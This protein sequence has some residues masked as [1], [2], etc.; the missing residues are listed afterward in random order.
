MF[1]PRFGDLTPAGALSALGHAFFTL[2]VGMGAVMAYGAYVPDDVSIAAT[3]VAVVCMDTGIAIVTGLV[4]FPI[5][6]ANGLDP[7]EG[8]GLI[9]HTL[10]LAFGQI[11]GGTIIATIFFLLL[12]FA[13]WTSAISLLEP[14]VAWITESRG[15]SRPT[16]A[17]LIG[18]AIWALGL[19]SVLSFNVL[20]DVDFMWG[21]YFDSADFLTSNIILPLGGIAIAV[22]A[23]WAMSR[24]S[25][26]DELNLANPK[27]YRLWRFAARF[28]APTAVILV[29]LNAVG[30]LP[31]VLALLGTAG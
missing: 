2:S 17:V 15:L 19:L 28:I 11:P 30:I 29:F 5:V 22:F 10:P 20:A 27:V 7:A 6:F 31:R 1:G 25:S 14:V 9:F 18:I 8:P 26:S 3:S 21:T 4:I 24:R 12:T 13:A 23:G 16:A